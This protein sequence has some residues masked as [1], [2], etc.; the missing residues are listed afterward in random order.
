MFN[1]QFQKFCDA[2]FVAIGLFCFG[3]PFSTATAESVSVRATFEVPYETGIFSDKPSNEFRQAALTKAK[4]EVW[5]AY[6]AKLDSSRQG[7]VERNRSAIETRLDD[8]VTNLNM[9]DEQVLVDAKRVRYTVRASVNSGLLITL[10]NSS[11]S[12]SAGGS[13]GSQFGFL[14]IP[15]KQAEA[16]SFDPNVSKTAKAIQAGSTKRVSKDQVTELEGGLSEQTLEGVEK[17]SALQ[18]SKSGS[19]KR[20][21]QAV[22]WEVTESKGV[23]TE[24][25]KV[26]TEAGFRPASF[27]KIMSECSDTEVDELIESVTQ[28]KTLNFNRT[29]NKA[30][31]E[32]LQECGIRFFS[33]GFLD[34][35]SIEPDSQ[36]GGWKVRV[37]VNV[38]V[39]DYGP[40]WSGAQR[41][42]SDVASIQEFSNGLG[43]TEEDAR[44]NALREAGRKAALIL[45]S[46]LRAQ[47]LN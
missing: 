28:S 41:I 29:N 39:S 35:D 13:L 32:A 19:V 31:R 10:L 11:S 9:L 2:F 34:V 46:Q 42:P 45:S 36:S 12:Q 23:V 14:F 30:V 6:Q 43:R 24:V 7:D 33:L 25:S 21:S 5:K 47:G 26:L 15:R 3:L 40:V 38:R 17:K 44:D 16:E 20:K 18:V 22:T 1:R 37:A 4:A 27:D 8:L